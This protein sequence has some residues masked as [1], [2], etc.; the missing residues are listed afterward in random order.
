MNNNKSNIFNGIILI[1]IGILLFGYINDF[2]SFDFSMREIAKYWPLLLV[3]AG[4]SVFFNERRSVYNP[5]TALFVAFAIPLGLFH[6]SVRGIDKVTNKIEDE[7]NIEFNSDNENNSNSKIDTVSNNIENYNVPLNSE[8]EYASLDINGGAVGFSLVES[9]VANVFEAKTQNNQ[10]GFELSDEKDG[11]KQEIEFK[12]MDN[13]GKFKFNNKN[14]FGKIEMKLST[15]PIWDLNLNVGASDIKFDLSNYKIKLM[16]IETG[17]SNLDL[18]LGNIISESDINISSG[19]AN[20]KVNIPKDAGC[21]I[22]T[23]S[24]LNANTFEGFK[25]IEKGKWQTDNFNKSTKKIKLKLD[26]GLSAVKVERY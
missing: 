13:K 10:N 18:K 24:V 1:T 23:E 7:L 4:I 5:T 17:A 25:E 22:I 16:D 6:F 21:Q 20:I 2:F 11:N 12:M 9:S 15:K 26:S 3:F 14:K 19:L 8:T